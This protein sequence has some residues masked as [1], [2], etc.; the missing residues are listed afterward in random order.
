MG[1]AVERWREMRRW[2][3]VL[4]PG[5]VAAVYGWAVF[6]STYGHPGV[7]GPD[8]IALGTDWMVMF[9]AVRLA[10]AGG[11][12]LAADGAAF[13][14]HLN[15]VF[16]DWLPEALFYRPWV[17]PP[18][19]L[20]VL[21]PFGKL[22]F[23]GAFVAFQVA[24]AGLLVSGLLPRT[25]GRGWWWAAMAAVVCPAASI[26][27]V[28]GQ[29]GFLVA[30]LLVW[31]VRLLPGRPL[32]AGAVLGVLSVKP[33]FGVLVPV[34]LLAGR[35]WRG[36]LGAG[37]STVGL[38]VA[39]LVVF[40]PEWWVQWGHQLAGSAGGEASEW[41]VFGRLW[42][43]SVF[44]CAALLGVAP[45]LAEVLQA[46]AMLAAAWCVY[47]V[48]RGG[49][50]ADE[51]LAVL[52]AGAVLAAVHCGQ[53]DFVLLTV[54][55][56]LWFR[57]KP[58]PELGHGIVVLVLWMAALLG[59][60]ALVPLGRFLPMLVLGFAAAATLGASGVVRVR[61]VEAAGA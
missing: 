1:A 42:G 28:D 27:A 30:G 53:Y 37:L 51:R 58:A 59:P 52:L 33:Q 7:I 32:L 47:R 29:C 50:T 12:G 26:N 14:A 20:V 48:F 9:E 35:E 25:R 36:V 21:W 13:T 46:G 45:G 4:V 40:G 16:A 24:S 10:G 61:A 6:V 5:M 39:S 3:P 38:A 23:F 44:A 56:V 2:A 60:P 19:F 22:G 54:A 41:T 17:Y 31:G 55:G 11:V 49:A 57:A 15:A 43:S 18:S 8:Y 34:V